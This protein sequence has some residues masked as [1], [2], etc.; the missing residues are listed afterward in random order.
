MVLIGTLLVWAAIVAG[1]ICALAFILL[2]VGP[3][4]RERKQLSDWAFPPLLPSRQR[5][6]E[7]STDD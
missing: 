7:K 1:A 4:A 3:P 6:G 5:A 2:A